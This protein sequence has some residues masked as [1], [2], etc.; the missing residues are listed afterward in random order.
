MRGNYKIKHLVGRDCMNTKI[1]IITSS[2]DLTCDY[3]V[4]KY[5]GVSFFRLDFDRFSDYA[6][7]VN[8]NGFSIKLGEDSITTDTCRSI[9]YRKP[10]AESLC[11]VFEDKYHAFVHKEA[12]SLIEGLA[13]SF[14]YR[15][16]TR[17]SIM[18]RA[19]N[20]V[21]QL[22]LAKKIGFKLP[23][24]S[25]TNAAS[26]I[27]RIGGVQKIV[28]PLAV[29]T[30]VGQG[31]KE[32]VQTNLLDEE[33]STEHLKY[34]P[35]YFQEY[36]GKDYEVRSTFIGKAEF[37]VR[38]QS[39]NKIDWRKANNK[40]TYEALQLPKSICDMCLRF[41]SD[42]NMSF[43]CFDFI[44][45]GGEFYFLEMNANGQWAWLEIE[46]GVNISKSI[47]EYLNEQ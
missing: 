22:M 21:V 14:E 43:G 24:S 7:E 28:K 2:N 1:L 23:S 41:M 17:P 9:Y 11:G 3:L 45:H 33:V 15:C 31:V 13:E 4:G 46:V 16:L 20:K 32:F 12:Y 34:T 35:A 6:I 42:L 27:E 29:G 47:V 38:I 36:V 5:S 39:E 26:N 19:N 18:R 37:S 40:L 8:E 30:V 10:V 25:I 44:V